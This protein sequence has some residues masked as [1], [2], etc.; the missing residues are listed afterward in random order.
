MIPEMT[1]RTRGLVLLGAVAWALG[2]TPALAAPKALRFG[3]VLGP[4]GRLVANATVLVDGERIQA[5]GTELTVPAGAERID[6]SGYTA[7]P[8]LIDVHTHMTYF[9]DGT[10]GTR[11]RGQAARHPGVTVFL[12]Q[13]NARRTL[14]TGVTTVR[15]LGASEY[16]DVA[17]RDL[18]RSGAMVG[19]RMFVSGYGLSVTRAAA[20]PGVG[21]PSGGT[22]DGV[23]EVTKVARQQIGA[24]ADWIKV[25]GSTGSYEDVTGF[26]TFGFD[27]MKAAAFVA[28]SFGKRIAIH[29]YGP[30]GARDAVR[31]GADSLEHAVDLDDETLAEMA[32]R[33]TVY[34]PTLDHNRYYRD[35]VDAYGFAPGTAERLEAFIDRN[36]ETLKRAVRAGVRVA[37]GSD[38]VYSG[39]GQNTRELEWFVRAGMSPGQALGAATTTGA[40]LLGM[41]KS[42]GSL[43]PGFLADIVAVE[44]DPLTD[45]GVVVNK[46][47]WVMKGG[48]VVVDKR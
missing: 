26:Q 15:D 20:R 32:R 37:M 47:R 44:G 10:P 8:G 17:M 4:D 45:V 2:V 19:P 7:I 22:A 12:A 28:H 46:V 40:A 14:E 16:T 3:R 42:L 21:A 30:A 43:Q 9:W 39:F 31:A 27:E 36:L 34:V 41:E 33:G 48:A 24:G 35:N 38:A 6:L 5:V 11:P 13:Q 29:S 23:D 1:R 25:Y 18:I